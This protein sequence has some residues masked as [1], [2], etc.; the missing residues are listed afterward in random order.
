METS[1]FNYH[2]NF[3]SPPLVLE[4]DGASSSVP[5]IAAKLDQK[6]FSTKYVYKPLNTDLIDFSAQYFYTKAKYHYDQIYPTYAQE[7]TNT[8]DRWGLKLKNESLFNTGFLEHRLVAGADYTDRKTDLKFYRHT[9]TR[10][11]ASPNYN[12]FMPNFYKELGVYLQDIIALGDF[13][14]TLGGRYD[15]FK[16]G[17]KNANSKQYEESKFSPKIALSYEIF[18]GINL[19]AGYSQTFRAP[20]PEESFKQGGIS[21]VFWYLP[22]LN[23]KPELAKE[24]E[25]GFSI[26]KQDLLGEDA[27]YLKATYYNGDI[28]DMIAPVERDDLGPAPRYFPWIPRTYVN[29]D[30]IESAKRYGYE[31]EAKYDISDL[32]LNLGYDHTK[33]YDKKTKRRIYIYADKIT[34]GAYYTY[35]AWGLSGGADVAHYMKPHYNETSFMSGGQLREYINK[36]FTIVN[37]R[38]MWQPKNFKK[39]LVKDG[40]KISFG[41]N[42]VF[43]KKYIHPESYR[44]TTAVGKGRNFYVDFEK[45]F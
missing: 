37:L 45:K 22:N 18:D 27:L 20:L 26:D 41:I 14:L 29:Y 17:L 1:F 35:R 44:D 6:D 34:F 25:V 9:P 19:L 15:K 13:E 8:D 28:K 16:R 11:I 5:S 30:N 4:S 31:L 23:L 38:A 43:D 21:P 2:E 40:L 12:T 3:I 36:D 32:A 7:Y 42:N 10:T 33:V 24:Y 39:D